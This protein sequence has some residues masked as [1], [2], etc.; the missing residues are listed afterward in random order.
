MK[1][2]EYEP[3]VVENVGDKLLLLTNHDAPNYKLVLVDPKNPAKENWK[4][5]IPEQPEVLQGVGTAGGKLFASYLKDASTRIVQ[6]DV[7]GKKDRE[8][9]LPGIGAAG[10]FG[11]KKED[12]QFFYT[13]S[14]FVA[15]PPSTNTTSNPA[16][17]NCS[18]SRK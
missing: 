17:R 10:G 13:F 16:N 12:G 5:I 2:F 18:A 1:G 14:S 3:S 7:T 9:K 8:I 4:V 15:P 11:G 6:Y